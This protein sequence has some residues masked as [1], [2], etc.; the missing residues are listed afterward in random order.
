MKRL[1]NA[2]EYDLNIK[3]SSNKSRKVKIYAFISIN[4]TIKFLDLGI[5]EIKEFKVLRFEV[6]DDGNINVQA[7]KEKS[8]ELEWC[9]EDGDCV[10]NLKCFYQKCVNPKKLICDENVEGRI[11]Y[12]SGEIIVEDFEKYCCENRRVCKP[13]SACL[14]ENERKCREIDKCK[15]SVTLNIEVN[16]R[17]ITICPSRVVINGSIKTESCKDNTPFIIKVLYDSGYF[18]SSEREP[19]FIEDIICIKEIRIKN[20]TGNFSCEF[21]VDKFSKNRRLLV[22]IYSREGE[23][24]FPIHF[25][26]LNI[27]CNCN[28]NE[29]ICKNKE[30]FVCKNGKWEKGALPSCLPDEVFDLDLCKCIKFVD[31]YDFEVYY[32]YSLLPCIFEKEIIGEIKDNRTDNRSIIIK[33]SGEIILPSY[34]T[35]IIEVFKKQ[36]F[37][38]KYIPIPTEDVIKKEVEVYIIQT[39]RKDFPGI[40][41]PTEARIILP[42]TRVCHGNVEIISGVGKFKCKVDQ[43]LIK[44][45][46]NPY[47]NRLYCLFDV[48]VGEKRKIESFLIPVC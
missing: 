32:E 23:E 35:L 34:L 36:D 31:L 27:S 18:I 25:F 30:I 14:V 2:G 12:E 8:K 46:C 28:E 9:I 3:I 41:S 19:P 29:K 24:V 37:I 6:N 22:R 17:E 40:L 11:I 45:Y 13:F 33:R 4:K 5:F 39:R 1:F 48:R 43:E 15:H 38:G 7:K 44:L 10:E 21:F 42:P 47:L 20:N 16:P 26:E